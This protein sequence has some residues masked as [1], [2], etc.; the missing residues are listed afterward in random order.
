MSFTRR[1][2]YGNVTLARKLKRSVTSERVEMFGFLTMS[3]VA[4]LVM[5]VALSSM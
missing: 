1:L 4:L 5:N 3:V 2:K